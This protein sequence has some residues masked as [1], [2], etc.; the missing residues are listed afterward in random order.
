MAFSVETRTY[1]A[2]YTAVRTQADEA[3]YASWSTENMRALSE[4]SHGI[5]LADENL[6]LRPAKFMSATNLARL[7]QIRAQR[8]PQGLFHAWMG[9][10]DQ[11]PAHPTA[12]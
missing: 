7:D 6:A 4:H 12:S 11:A 2:L 3:K 8:D 9:R 10:P 5:Q 1:L